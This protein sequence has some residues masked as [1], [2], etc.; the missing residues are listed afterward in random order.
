MVRGLEL[1]EFFYILTMRLKFAV[2]F[3]NLMPTLSTDGYRNFV[4]K[5]SLVTRNAS[6][7][8]QTSVKGPSFR[9]S[10]HIKRTLIEFP[11]RGDLIY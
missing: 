7:H 4:G 2:L 6:N 9:Q 8:S 1:T 11:K 10:P 3:V 5:Y